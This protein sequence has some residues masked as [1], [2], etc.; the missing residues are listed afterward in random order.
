MLPGPRITISG[1]VLRM[2]GTK[3][4]ISRAKAAASYPLGTPA[5][6]AKVGSFMYSA[7]VILPPI[8]LV[9]ARNRLAWSGVHTPA[10]SR[11]PA[12]VAKDVMI[13]ASVAWEKSMTPFHCWRVNTPLNPLGGVDGAGASESW[14]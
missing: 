4:A 11:V 10:A 2:K 1:A 8:D 13:F 6:A 7:A 12:L 9:Y 14:K 3:T 5:K